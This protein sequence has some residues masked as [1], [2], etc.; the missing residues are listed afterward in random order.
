MAK[1]GKTRDFKISFAIGPAATM[2]ERTRAGKKFRNRF[3]QIG[4]RLPRRG[5]RNFSGNIET[6]NGF[7]RRDAVV[8]F[9]EAAPGRQRSR[10][11]Q[12]QRLPR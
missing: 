1:R 8:P 7:T 9:G 6:L 11:G 5:L 3:A 2:P 10:K 12:P 4:S